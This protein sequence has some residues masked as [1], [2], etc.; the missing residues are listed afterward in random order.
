M[1]ATYKSKI[2]T[3]VLTWNSEDFIIDCLSSLMKSEYSTNIIV[4]DNDSSDNTRKYVHDKYPEITLIN[5]GS[6]LGYAGGNNVGI[7][8]ALDINTDYV[9]IINPDTY[10]HKDCVKLL[11]ER[12]KNERELAAVSPK[13]YYQDTKYIWF[14]GARVNWFSGNTS[15]YNGED[16]GQYDSK[17]YTKRLTGC[18]M[19]LSVKAIRKVGLMDERFFLFY[20]ETD[21]SVR[22]TEAGY[23]LGMEPAAIFWHNASSST[24]GYTNPLY[25]YYMTRNRLLFVQKHKPLMLPSTFFISIY[26][27]AL[28]VAVTLK[29]AGSH[30]ARLVLKSI[31]KGYLD[32]VM[33]KFY[34][35][36]IPS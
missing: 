12:M 31:F 23:K 32:Y 20:E 21:W 24:G 9:F 7:N 18:A 30:R 11:V 1:N 4:I 5:T 13:I 26:D 15:Q 17:R 36:K 2:T 3:L 34:S 6:N 29:R 25:H 8:Y 19:L 33:R 35:R 22:F 14:A 27:S 16:I 28:A 10:I